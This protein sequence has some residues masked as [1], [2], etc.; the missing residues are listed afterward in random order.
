MEHSGNHPKKAQ[1]GFSIETTSYWKTLKTGENL[2]KK[3]LTKSNE[4]FLWGVI[5]FG[6]I[7]KN[8]LKNSSLGAIFF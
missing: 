1:K 4:L 3:N 7:F 8:L 6:E 5:K 2:A